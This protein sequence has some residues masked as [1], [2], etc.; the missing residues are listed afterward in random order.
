M[1][2]T[3]IIEAIDLYEKDPITACETL[4]EIR[5]NIRSH[6]GNCPV[7]WGVDIGEPDGCR[8]MLDIYVLLCRATEPEDDILFFEEDMSATEIVHE[9]FDELG[10]LCADENI[11]PCLSCRFSREMEKAA[12]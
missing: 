12:V 9:A 6:A 1:Y 5:E 11:M 4:Y 2:T 3:K 8:R 10:K 7:F